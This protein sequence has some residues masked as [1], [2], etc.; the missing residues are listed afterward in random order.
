MGGDRVIATNMGPNGVT[1]GDNGLVQGPHVSDPLWIIIDFGRNKGEV[2]M[3]PE[4]L[5]K[6]PMVR[7]D[8]LK[9]LRRLRVLGEGGEAVLPSERAIFVFDQCMF[10]SIDEVRQLLEQLYKE[11][12]QQKQ[13]LERQ[14]SRA[15][16][17]KK[18]RAFIEYNGGI[19]ARRGPVQR[20][21]ANQIRGRVETWT[22]EAGKLAHE[23]GLPRPDGVTQGWEMDARKGAS[24]DQ[25]QD[26]LAMMQ[27]IMQQRNSNLQDLQAEINGIESPQMSTPISPTT[28]GSFMMS[29]GRLQL[30]RTS[31]Q[32]VFEK[33]SR[34]QQAAVK[35]KQL[36]QAAAAGDVAKLKRLLQQNIDVNIS[37]WGGA[38]PLMAASRHGR[39]AAVQV[40]LACRA[41][42]GR[43]DE[44]GRTAV[45]HAQHAGS[46]KSSVTSWLRGYGGLSGKELRAK[47]DAVARQIWDVETQFARLNEYKAK[48]PS[49][50]DLN[51][52][53]QLL[54]FDTKRKRSAMLRRSSD[55][56][57][58]PK[59]STP[60]SSPDPG[61]PRNI[62]D[63][64]PSFSLA[65]FVNSM[66]N[67][68][69]PPF[70]GA[71]YNGAGYNGA[72]YNGAGYNGVGYSG[73]GYS[74]AGYNG[75]GYGTPPLPLRAGTP[76][77]SLPGIAT[78]W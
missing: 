57:I 10:S 28:P 9:L 51:Y 71:G 52:H 13:D 70:P 73:A 44:Y 5:R 20:D 45:D 30:Q 48:L 26:Y 39:E 21:A 27:E 77:L 7:D 25:L 40:L 56:Q 61:T 74:G 6:A 31:S 53:K 36:I 37:G 38:T 66:G 4:N 14:K 24:K 8:F 42:P 65:G 69:R 63:G 60:R 54:E 78:R 1:I 18:Q 23:G 35:S 12:E 43:T 72:G 19:F 58:T 41:D 67:L 17:M 32:L 68:P 59:A 64:T 46:R 76:P 15:E 33:T 34:Q 50:D 62:D 2:P 11:E 75:S 55:T 49:K 47:V 22:S 29:G 16:Q 3:L